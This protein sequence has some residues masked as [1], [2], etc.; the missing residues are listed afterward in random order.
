M[1]NEHSPL[2]PDRDPNPFPLHTL[3]PPRPT[4][5]SEPLE[6]EIQLE[7][8]IVRPN[9]VVGIAKWQGE[10]F[11]YKERARE[12]LLQEQRAATIIADLGL[13]TPRTIRLIER[14]PKGLLLQEYIPHFS[15]RN[16]TVL[17][18]SE[19]I[20][21]RA[22]LGDC[23][24]FLFNASKP[25]LRTGFA[26]ATNDRFLFAR[27]QPGGRMEQC[28]TDQHFT[29]ATIECSYSSLLETRFEVDG[30]AYRETLGELLEDVR[31]ILAPST[32]RPLWLSHGDLVE[33]NVYRSNGSSTKT[34]QIP[35]GVID[36]EVTGTN[37]AVGD[38]VIPLIAMSYMFDYT[39]PR[40]A[41]DDEHGRAYSS[42]SVCSVSR[43]DGV[44]CLDGILGFQ[45]SPPRALACRAF[46]ERFARPLVSAVAE[47]ALDF[48]YSI[49]A[50]LRAGF[51]MRLMGA[52]NFL[53]YSPNDQAR[54]F[55]LTFAL[56]G[57]PC[58]DDLS[59]SALGRFEALL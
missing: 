55:G 27:A 1:L 43:R 46:L 20:E 26:E 28:Y 51:F 37:W 19:R 54:V 47:G 11:F 13:A 40:Y 52:H 53:P 59:P 42:K 35:W 23:F 33:T 17:I 7:S 24:E 14:G 25:S 44:I 18:E 2:Y 31:A 36:L 4:Q 5:Q 15:S 49:D 12:V 48:N 3:R 16:L 21:E 45:T 39:L 58:T 6:P 29:L 32:R 8:R 10:T 22:L 38:V 30:I 50:Q 57:T 41:P 56:C 34:G 9:S